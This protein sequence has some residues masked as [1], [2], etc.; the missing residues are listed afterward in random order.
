MRT[1][2]HG[3]QRS[4]AH[5]RAVMPYC[6]CSGLSQAERLGRFCLHNDLGL[7]CLGW[8]VWCWL[9]CFCL[10]NC[11]LLG[12][13]RFKVC[14]AGLFRV[15]RR[16]SASCSFEVTWCRHIYSLGKPENTIHLHSV[17]AKKTWALFYFYAI[18]HCIFFLLGFHFPQ[19]H[20][21]SRLFHCYCIKVSSY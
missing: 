3:L 5:Y 15:Y 13:A 17:T 4:C 11:N 20:F 8:T 21:S 18:Y 7:K 16:A 12:I 1:V 6:G 2:F 9:E 14:I 19:D 10:L